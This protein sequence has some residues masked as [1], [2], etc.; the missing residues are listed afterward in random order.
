MS[1]MLDA[2]CEAILQEYRDNLP[3]FG[4]VAAEVEDT[5]RRTFSDAGLFLAGI[6]SRVKTEASLAGKL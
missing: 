1:V 5:L 6:E 3:E 2:H 4:R